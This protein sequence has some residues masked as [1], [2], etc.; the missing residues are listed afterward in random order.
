[1]HKQV[2]EKREQRH[3]AWKA[4]CSAEREIAVRT[5]EVVRQLRNLG[6]EATRN[7]P[8]AVT[9]KVDVATKIVALLSGSVRPA[10][11]DEPVTS[12]RESS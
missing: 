7:S 9:M 12:D 6:I 11:E 8:D 5:D 2:D 4:K 3:L 10:T 1:M